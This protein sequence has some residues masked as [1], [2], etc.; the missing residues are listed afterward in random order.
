MTA[1]SRVVAAL[2]APVDA[3]SLVAF[4]VLFGALMIVAV[5]RFFA[6]GWIHAY[7]IEPSHF[8]TYYGFDW[9]RPWPGAGMYLHFAAMGGCAALVMIGLW[10]RPAVAGFAA[11]FT[12]A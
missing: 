4:R 6:H 9:V 12:Y 2:R 3:S 7:F 8:F 5:A 1:T 10:Y 11:L